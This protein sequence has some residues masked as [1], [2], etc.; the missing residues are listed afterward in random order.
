MQQIETFGDERHLLYCLY[1]GA[2]P[3]TREH[4]PSRVLLDKPYPDNLPVVGACQACNV[5]FSPDEDYLA[6]AV[7]V[8]LAGTADPASLERDKVRRILSDRP[9]LAARFRAALRLAD[10]ETSLEIEVRRV[11]RVLTKLARGHAFFE[12][13]EPVLDEPVNVAFI[14]LLLLSSNARRQFEVPPAA[15]AWPPPGSRAMLQL[16]A[17]WPAGEQR[18]IVVQPSRYRYVVSEGPPVS[19]R[20]VLSEYLACEVTWP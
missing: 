10:Q 4:V 6:C 5:A 8:A 14:P 1:C 11:Q 2:E 15:A 18:W 17:S 9:A 16:L 7:A 13:S 20:I 3:D 12:L 19:V